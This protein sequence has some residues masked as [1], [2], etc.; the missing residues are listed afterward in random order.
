LFAEKAARSISEMQG[1][2][3]SV[4]DV[5]IF[6]EVLGYD[7]LTV[8][9]YGFANLTDFARYIFDFIDFIG[10]TS[11]TKQSTVSAGSTVATSSHKM[12]RSTIRF[13]EGLALAFPIVGML[14]VLFVFGV[15]LWMARIL[16]IEITTAFLGGVFLGI[17]ISEGP[18]QAFTRLFSFYSSQSNL[19]EV[20][21]AIR[22]NDYMVGAALVVSSTL[23]LVLAY[24]G[25]VPLSLAV[26][27]IASSVTI[28]V[29]RAS[30][31]VIFAQKKLVQMVAAYAAALTALVVIYLYLPSR[32]IDLALR[33]IP[34]SIVGSVGSAATME[35]L[36]R[37][38]SALFAAF[39]ILLIP[40]D[41]YRSK[42][43]SSKT[44]A[45]PNTPHFYTPFNIGDKTVQ[46]RL[47]VQLWETMPYFIFGTFFFLMIFADRIISWIFNPFVVDYGSLPLEFNAVYHT[48]A[49]P[50][51]VILL[52]TTIVSY[53]LLSPIYEDLAELNS[54]VSIAKAASAE[55]ILQRSYN[56]L[57]I[58]A[59]LTSTSVAFLLNYEALELMHYLRGGTIS[60]QILRV[61]SI[62]DVFISIFFVNAM[63]LTLVNR[64]KVTAVIS[65][66]CVLII[67][68]VGMLF[69]IVGFQY[70]IWAYLLSSFVAM[71]SSTIY[72]V[73]IRGKFANLFLGRYV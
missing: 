7:D 19:G 3:S 33:F 15:S 67:V 42:I 10:E 43:M 61:A 54:K 22:R 53:V 34:A 60:L 4:T 5:L 58:A 2:I 28:A 62:G 63:F 20:K 64:V 51:L 71:I 11:A 27:A 21:R 72:C 45:P 41:Y 47:G 40:A 17:L 66:F 24:L 46:S 69:G 9:K 13:L 49:D 18:M 37:Y 31:L 16:P 25:G 26:I 1:N 8:R 59:M 70:I 65:V 23:L 73:S 39:I 44:V 14:A 38:F 30:Y 12:K 6:L 68:S 29:H 36:I 32:A 56:K 52:A 48:G 57:L 35:L 55:D 50:A